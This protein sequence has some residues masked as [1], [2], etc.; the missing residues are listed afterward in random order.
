MATPATP[1]IALSCASATACVA[2][3][4]QGRAYHFNGVGWTGP[5]TLVAG[6]VGPGGVAVSCA[7]VQ[8]C[9]AVPTGGDQV[10]V[11]NGATWSAPT[12]LPGANGLESVG[13]APSGYCA[14][15]DGEGYAFALSGG[16]WQETSGDWGSVSDISCASSSFCVS[17]SGGIS[18]WDGQQWSAPQ[19]NGVTT[20]YNGVSCPT[21]VF[22]AAVDAGGQ[23]Q[24]WNGTAWSAPQNVLPAPSGS[25]APS[26]GAAPLTG[27]S[28]PTTTFCAAVAA[29]VGVV[30]WLGGSWIRADDGGDHEVTAISCP[31]ASLCVAVDRSG[32]AREAGP[33]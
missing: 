23:V 21:P 4:Q 24:W 33:G 8:Q 1:L 3:D 10:A 14:A 18:Q 6:P 20:S 15:V 19:N 32:L 9:V 5:V 26:G 22:C 13:C 17:V 12:T 7:S 29:G 28:C 27:V 2:L 25:A 16:S 30:E 11:W 31:T